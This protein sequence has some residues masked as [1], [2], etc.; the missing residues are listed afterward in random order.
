[1]KN[2]TNVF[3]TVFLYIF[4]RNM[5]NIQ[6]NNGTILGKLRKGGGFYADSTLE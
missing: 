6:T 5:L 4:Q 1:M 3:G 2:R